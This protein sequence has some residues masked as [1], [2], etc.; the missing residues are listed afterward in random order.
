MTVPPHPLYHHRSLAQPTES[1]AAVTYL[2]VAK[3]SMVKTLPAVK[4]TPV[5]FLG[6]EVPLEKE[7]AT[8]ARILRLP[9]CSDGKESACHAGD[10]GSVSEL[11]EPLEEGM[12]LTPV[13]LPRDSPRT[14]EPGVHGAARSWTWLMT[15]HSPKATYRRGIFH[16]AALYVKQEQSFSFFFENWK[17]K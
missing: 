7:Q 10:L 3:W 8:H 14:E 11:E 4:Q 1:Y 5:Q 6:Q 9:W 2:H 15:K 16:A 17:M 12:Q 13:F